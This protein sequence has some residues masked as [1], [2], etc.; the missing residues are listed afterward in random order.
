MDKRKI[1]DYAISYS[2]LLPFAVFFI[3]FTLIPIGY[4]FY[5][6]VHDGNFLQAKF[7]WAGMKN[8][9][10]VLI[11]PDFQGAFKNT[12]IY[13]LIEVPVSQF[14]G[15]FFALLIRKKTRFSHACEII[16]FLP[17]LISMVV[18]SVLI[19]YIISNNGPLNLLI[20]FFGMQ[21]INWLNGKFSAKMAVMML[22]LCKGGTFI[23]FVEMSSM[24]SLPADCLESARIDGANAM[25]EAV[26]VV[27][28]LIRNA[29]ILCV[30]M[31][32]IWQFQIF[33]SVYML[34][35]GGP[36][37]ATQTVIY[38]IYQYSFKYYRVGFGAAASL[39]FLLVILVIYGLENLLLREKETGKRRGRHE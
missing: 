17:M 37:G 21:P 32:T 7:D 6:S 8:F 36:L 12:F 15:I 5:L 22:D 18:A 33:E 25:Q 26:F 28:P 19:S 4:V 24:R 16:F 31:N 14:L 34:T 10:D 9:K 13:M 38:E 39:V 29:I 2:F 23:I 27:L 20:Q 1:R 35:N 3:V 11:T 30:T